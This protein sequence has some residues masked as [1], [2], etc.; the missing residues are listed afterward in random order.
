MCCAGPWTDN[1]I[2][3]RYCR[4]MC[5]FCRT[6][7]AKVMVPPCVQSRYSNKAEDVDDDDDEDAPLSRR[8]RRSRPTKQAAAS[9][10]S[11]Q[12][13]LGE[14]TKAKRRRKKKGEPQTIII[15]D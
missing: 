10:G 3:T 6:R 13:Q 11:R 14:Y 1:A 7:V 8:K 2:A 9:S 12:S 5:D 4:G 15:M